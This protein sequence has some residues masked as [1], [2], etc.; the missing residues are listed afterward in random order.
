MFSGTDLKRT[1]LFGTEDTV[2]LY[3][4][5]LTLGVLKALVIMA[6]HDELWQTFVVWASAF[7]LHFETEVLFYLSYTPLKNFTFFFFT[8]FML[9]C[10]LQCDIF[11]REL[12]RGV[13][14]QTVSWLLESTASGTSP[15]VPGRSPDPLFSCLSSF[16]GLI[17]I[18]SGRK[19]KLQG[20]SLVLRGHR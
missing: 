5:V 12:H 1:S 14:L 16:H 8:I 2:Q 19:K 15:K 3:I 6:Y 9:I 17:L 11:P 18:Q 4:S 10:F 7:P 13:Y 20:G